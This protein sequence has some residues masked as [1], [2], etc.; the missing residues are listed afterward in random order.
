MLTLAQR[1]AAALT[2]N[3]SLSQAGLARACGISTASVS[4]WKTGKTESIG[5]KHLRRAATYLQCS[6]DW[7]ETGFGSPA[8]ADEPPASGVEVLSNVNLA[9]ER[10]ARYTYGGPVAATLV[11]VMGTLAMGETTGQLLLQCNPNAAPIGTLKVQGL[12]PSAFALR[13]VGDGHYPVA[14]HGACLVVEPDAASVPGEL[15]LLE[16]VDGHYLLIELVL[17]RADSYTVIPAVGGPRETLSAHL[18]VRALAVSSIVAAS[19]FT[20][21]I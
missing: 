6:R 20:A 4:G 11:P 10:A 8:W 3:S 21:V 9:R 14:R 19:Q 2:R 15:V 1:I 5:A 7:L 18:V 16:M 12:G 13:I 17:A